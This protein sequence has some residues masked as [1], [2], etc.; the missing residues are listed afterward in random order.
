VLTVRDSGRGMGPDVLD[1]AF[2][3]FFTTK[4]PGKGTGL[5]LPTVYGLVEQHGGT[6]ELSSEPGHGTSVS[7]SLPAVEHRSSPT[8]FRERRPEL[9]RGTELLLIVEDDEGT[10][11]IARSALRHLGYE[12]LLAEDGQVALETIESTPGI[13][14]V[15]SDV[16]MPR[17]TGPELLARLRELGRPIPAFAFWTGY[18][19]R[20]AAA[21][22]EESVPVL[23]KPWTL[24]ALSVFV[25]RCIDEREP[26]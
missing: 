22:L 18:A 12:V 21:K 13:A 7:I 3:P 25:R 20:E 24:E 4:S 26:K 1:R 16:V 8:P 14:L 11:A 9:A 2:E 15:L 10:R 5:G 6:I 17:M 19:P 23:T